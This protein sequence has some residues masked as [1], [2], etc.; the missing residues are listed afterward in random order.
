M[1]TKKINGWKISVFSVLMLMFGLH[2]VAAQNFVL[3]SSPQVGLA[4]YWVVALDVNGDGKLDLVSANYG[5]NTLTVLTNN[6]FGVFGFNAT[7]PVGS[8]PYSVVAADVNGDHK[9]DLIAANSNDGTLIVLTNNGG[10]IFGSNA[11]YSVGSGAGSYPVSVAIADVNSDSTLDL[12]SANYN[13]NTLTVL[14]NNGSG[15]FGSNATYSVGTNPQQVMAVNVNGDGKLALISANYGDSTLTVLTNNG[16]GVF[17]S[18]ATYNVGGEP[19]SFAAVDVNGD[20][21]LDLITANSGD[22]T[23]T[24]L[25]NNGNGGFGSNATYNVGYYPECVAA[26]DVNGDGKADLITANYSPDGSG[27]TLTVLTNNGSGTFT[28]WGTLTV[29][30]GPVFVTAAD[31][32]GDGT[33]DLIAANFGIGNGNTLS[34]LL[35]LPALNIQTYNAGPTLVSWFPAWPGYALQGRTNLA[36]GSWS[37]VSNPTGTNSVPILP[38]TGYRFFRLR[39]P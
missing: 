19:V 17:G 30:T 8:G 35:N 22:S 2:P 38:A 20:G 4:P 7:Y 29:G 16:S 9:M 28:N 6:G 10:G 18:N 39:H 37:D 24:V 14:T 15:V 11:T 33:P 21:K 34:V 13:D 27:N 3:S 36:T 31:L 12:I 5:E 23:L 25:T 26:A 32:N 1:T